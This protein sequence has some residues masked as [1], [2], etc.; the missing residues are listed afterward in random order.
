MTICLQNVKENFSFKCLLF[1]ALTACQSEPSRF[2]C[3]GIHGLF[4]AKLPV[5]SVTPYCL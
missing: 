1:P 5:W 2:L 4:L 3:V